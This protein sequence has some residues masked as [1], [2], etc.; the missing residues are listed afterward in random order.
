MI[1]KVNKRLIDIFGVL[2]DKKE[3]SIKELCKSLDLSERSVRYEIE[4]INYILSINGLDEIRKLEK[5]RLLLDK[6]EKVCTL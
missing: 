3:T 5:G 4:N 2:I 1:M 6:N